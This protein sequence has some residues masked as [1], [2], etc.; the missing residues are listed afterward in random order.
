MFVSE[1]NK[2]DDIDWEGKELQL[3]I[4]AEPAGNT[5]L[6]IKESKIVSADSVH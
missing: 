6:S 5:A 2:P 3:E 1:G 4:L